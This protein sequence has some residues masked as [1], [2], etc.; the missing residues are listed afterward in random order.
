MGKPIYVLSG[1]NLNMLGT[2]EPDIY[3]HQTLDDVRALCEA[4]ASSLGHVVVF[5]Q[6]NHEGVLVDWIQE[7]REKASALIINGA[8]YTHTSIAILDALRAFD[9]PVIE[10]HL[11]NPFRREPFR[12]H[13]YVS[14]GSTG[15]I[16]GLKEHGY[17]L[18]IDALANMLESTS[19]DRRR[20][21]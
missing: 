7:A 5:R 18:A 10:V 6:S 20:T 19:N 11:S 12:R 8:A 16:V 3:G 9:K 1:P 14:L 4:R 17:V 15:V 21:N 13:S 2:R